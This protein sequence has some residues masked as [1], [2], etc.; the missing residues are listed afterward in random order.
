[1]TRPA[2]GFGLALDGAG[3]YERFM[4]GRFLFLAILGFASASGS[5][6]GEAL[7]LSGLDGKD[8]AP[9]DAEGKKAAV[10]FFISPYCPTSNTFT[11]EMNA[12][13]KQF[14]ADFAFRFVH[15]DRTVTEADRKQHAAMMEIVAPVLTDA[16]QALA[17]RLQA[18]TTPEVVVVGPDEKLL[19][20][21]RINDLYLGP[22]KRQREVKTHDLRDA[23][24]AIREGR[25]VT[26]PRTE[27]MGC[28][29]VIAP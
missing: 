17:K 4:T 8:V 10:I 27:A 23:L 13:A 18:K 21:G 29:I 11:P 26:N 5:F 1:M 3:N 28:G 2:R 19:Y 7:K 6:G 12:I 15:S 20:Q 25:P 24:A 14:E 9:L 16:D 22:T